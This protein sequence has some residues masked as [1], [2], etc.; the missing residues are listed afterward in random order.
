MNQ[1]TEINQVSN[2]LSDVSLGI[3]TYCLAR[4][5]VSFP[6]NI[7]GID[8]VHEVY[9]VEQDGISAVLSHVSLKEYNEETLEKN[10]TVVAWL[11]PRAK[12]HEEVIEFV[13]TPAA[14]NQRGISNILSS[15][16]LSL[17][18]SFSIGSG[19]GGEN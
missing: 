19:S 18:P 17:S 5:P 2:I 3:Y 11:V 15:P 7:T 6:R 10:M 16:L 9:S 8:G 13:M 14:S 12:R 1:K 4:T